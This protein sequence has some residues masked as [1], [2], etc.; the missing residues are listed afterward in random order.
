MNIK[1]KGLFVIKWGI[2]LLLILVIAKVFKTGIEL[3]EDK[4]LTI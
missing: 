2:I 3:Q 1:I 4:N